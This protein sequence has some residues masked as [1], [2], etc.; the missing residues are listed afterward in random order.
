[1]SPDSFN[2]RCTHC[3]HTGNRVFVRDKEGV[4]RDALSPALTPDDVRCDCGAP[5][6]RLEIVA[7]NAPSGEDTHG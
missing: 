3:G 5:S 1:M 6:D 7:V 4:L 2:A